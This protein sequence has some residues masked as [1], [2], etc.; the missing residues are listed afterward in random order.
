MSY[1]PNPINKSFDFTGTQYNT[2]AK[3]NAGG[4]YF[5]DDAGCLFPTSLGITSMTAFSGTWAHTASTG[6]TSS[7]QTDTQISGIITSLDKGNWQA[8]LYLSYSPTAVGEEAAIQLGAVTQSNHVGF[9][10]VIYDA[11]AGASELICLL[12]TNDGDDT[13]TTQYTGSALAGTGDR[14]YKIKSVNSVISIY[15]DYD[16]AWHD[17]KG[18]QNAICSYSYN[19]I[20]IAIYKYAAVNLAPVYIQKLDITYL[21]NSEI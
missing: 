7:G 21:V 17:Y 6:W 10:S 1:Y 13:I 20:Y 11:N 9:Y 5:H 18:H 12:R 2:K 15:D 4:I 16:N 14:L 19:Y 3:C 8:D